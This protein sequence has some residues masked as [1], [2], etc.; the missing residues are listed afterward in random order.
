MT[1]T[2]DRVIS[3]IG[4]IVSSSNFSV[5]VNSSFSSPSNIWKAGII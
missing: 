3:K 5:Y 4:G 2:R 1:T